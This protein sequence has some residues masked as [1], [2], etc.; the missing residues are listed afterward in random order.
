MVV[1]QHA[2]GV[3]VGDG[4]QQEIDRLP[5]TAGSQHGSPGSSD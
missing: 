5:W 4:R 1:V 3:L 2:Y